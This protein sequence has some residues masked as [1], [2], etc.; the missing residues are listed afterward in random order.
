MGFLVPPVPAGDDRLVE[1]HA[2]R[3]R[4]TDEQRAN[5]I[6][7]QEN[8]VAWNAYFIECR[9]QIGRAHV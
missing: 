2:A 6:W 8:N 4:M 5:L 7:D 1:I 3:E 9:Q